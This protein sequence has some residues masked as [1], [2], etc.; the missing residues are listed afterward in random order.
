MINLILPYFGISYSNQL[1]IRIVS[2]IIFSAQLR[3]ELEFY[4]GAFESYKSQL[5]QEIE[6]KWKKKEEE[7]G[8]R[9]Q[10]EM[11]KKMHEIRK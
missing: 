8:N 4:Q 11:Q 10:E 5:Q 6:D 7:L 3:G 9:H 1:F 2:L